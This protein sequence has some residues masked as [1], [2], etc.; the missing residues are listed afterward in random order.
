MRS[1][2]KAIITLLI[3]L[4]ANGILDISSAKVMD[5]SALQGT[6]DYFES[7]EYRIYIPDTIKIIRGVYFNLPG[8]SGDTRP[9][10]QDSLFDRLANETGFA[11]LG[12]SWKFRS[13]LYNNELWGTFKSVIRALSFFAEK[14]LHSE[15]NY[16]PLFL[17]GY[18]A[19]GWIAYYFTWWIP[20]R[21]LGFIA[22]KFQPESFN[23]GPAKKVPGYIFYDLIDN[24]DPSAAFDLNRSKGALWCIAKEPNGSHDQ[25]TDRNLL[26]MYFKDVLD[27]RLPKN[28]IL[29]DHVALNAIYESSGWLGDRESL[30]IAPYD[31]FLGNKSKACW[32]P[33]KRVAEK[34]QQFVSGGNNF[35]AR[36]DAFS[37]L[38]KN[39]YSI[40]DLGSQVIERTFSKQTDI[41][42]SNADAS[43]TGEIAGD[44]AGY[45]ISSA[46]DVNG[47]GYSDFLIGV[48][49]KDG[50][51][52]NK[53]NAGTVY[54]FLGGS[55]NKWGKDFKINNAD[56]SFV[57]EAASDYAGCSVSGVGDVNGDGLSDFII[58]ARGNKENGDYSGKIYLIF[59]RRDI[60]WGT[61]FNLSQSDVVFNGENS[62]NWAGAHL[63]G[64]GDVNG[65][66]LADF[67]IGA[68]GWG[69]DSTNFNSG[70]VY[71]IFGKTN[72][73]KHYNLS[74][75]DVTF[76][77]EYPRDGAGHSTA[78]AGDVNGDGLADFLVGTKY[79]YDNDAQNDCK[80]YLILG[81]HINEWK[82]QYNLSQANGSFIGEKRFDFSGYTLS[83]AGDIN[84][85]GLS[86]F[87]ISAQDNSFGEYFSGQTYII[88]GRPN[89]DWGLNFNLSGA[90]AS[91]VGENAFD[92][93]SFA[94]SSSDLNKDGLND[95][96]ISAPNYNA[97]GEFS[98]KIYV[99]LGRKKAD[100]GLHF[101][102]S[103]A[104]IS[105]TGESSQDLAGF[106]VAAAGDVNK[107][108]YPD[109]LVGAMR[110]NPQWGGSGKVYLIMG[111]NFTSITDP[112]TALGET[113][114]FQNYPN[115]FNANTSINFHLSKQGFVTL[116]LFNLL[117][118]KLSTLISEERQPGDY[119]IELDGSN[120][121]SGVYFYSLHTG[122]FYQT[123][124]LILL[125]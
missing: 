2:L 82:T 78:A 119:R 59:G 69:P 63:S 49:G 87:L 35:S 30:N 37:K 70:K 80:T 117:G 121:A 94:T 56:A 95:I 110:I 53:T 89:A 44:N 11:I 100:W 72:W 116:T 31:S 43:F 123:K 8:S 52:L 103:N 18:S 104:D 125:K 40:R 64:C 88:L 1:I 98:G 22:E 112:N 105:F 118:D 9:A 124:K 96:I 61:D 101:S 92:I 106:S 13:E 45:A 33:S 20:D 28:T 73:E 38:I 14:T 54:L 23:A 36:T 60:T 86:D 99:I 25:I 42:L 91:F 46:G 97:A 3:S 6:N 21:I 84:G 24:L 79:N 32:F 71:L 19:G 27:L 7:A 34:W 74:Q 29:F 90:D 77:G 62:F 16:A 48:P 15:L 66:N 75:A 85:D 51:G 67:I 17:E 81:R 10:V 109:I 4:I 113:I 108:G 111:K 57:G 93:S 120:L 50:A 47:D 68:E 12:V 39:D 76:M 55:E 26:E 41:S 65:D 115:P 107:D 102:L 5:Y 83:S 58:G 122:E 114:L